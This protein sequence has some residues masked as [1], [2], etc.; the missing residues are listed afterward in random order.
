V[1]RKEFATTRGVEVGD[2]V[3]EVRR[4]YSGLRRDI[5]LGGGYTLI[6]KRGNRRLMFTIGGSKVLAIAGGPV[7]WVLQQECV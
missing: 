3:R 5:D 6:W 1:A 7:P 4:K 2:R